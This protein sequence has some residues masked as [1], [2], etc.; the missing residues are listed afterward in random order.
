MGVI[1]QLVLQSYPGQIAHRLLAEPRP[2]GLALPLVIRLLPGQQF[3]GQHHILQGGVLGKQVERLEHKAQMEPFLPQVLLPAPGGVRGVEE[4][5]AVDR[6]LARCG[7]LQQVDAPQ[8]GGLAAARGPMMESTRPCSRERS[9]PLSTSDLRRT[10]AVPALPESPFF[11]P[12][13]TP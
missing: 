2:D 11:S 3:R 12:L 4:R 9:M 13:L 10:C 8:Q 6:H 7:P 1:V 5:G